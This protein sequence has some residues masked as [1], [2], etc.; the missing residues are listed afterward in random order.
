MKLPNFQAE[1]NALECDIKDFV[2]TYQIHPTEFTE[3]EINHTKLVIE[4]IF[5]AY[6]KAHN[7]LVSLASDGLIDAK[8]PLV[9]KLRDLIKTFEHTRREYESRLLAQQRRENVYH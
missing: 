2:L 1:I 3:Q 8:H 6:Q 9:A 7:N 4:K 5:N